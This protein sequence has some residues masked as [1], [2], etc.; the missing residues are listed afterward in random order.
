VENIRRLY[1]ESDDRFCD[2]LVCKMCRHWGR[3]LL[4]NCGLPL[5]T[6]E[7]VDRLVTIEGLEHLDAALAKG[8]GVMLA[9]AHFGNFEI[10]NGA[11]AVLGYPL[12]TIL[13]TVDNPRLDT[14]MDTTRKATGLGIIKKEK[15]ARDIIR[16][17]REGAVVTINVDQNAAFNNIFVPFFGELAAT[18]STPAVMS[19]RTGA[20][21][22]V[23]H[24]FRDEAFDRY[25]LVIHPAVEIPGIG[26]TSADI[27][28]ILML[29]NEKLEGAIKRAPE[30]WHWAHRR[31]KTRPDESNLKR[32]AHEGELIRKWQERNDSAAPYHE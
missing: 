2:D 16:H 28:Y 13:R 17:L 29:V 15:A 1:P 31:W 26:D 12:Q 20:P 14:L 4:E 19:L 7:N 27:R 11:L 24:C 6:S 9:T 18:F 10:G 21:I 23:A 32:V 25:R 22:V 8:H 30:Q 3:F 5:L